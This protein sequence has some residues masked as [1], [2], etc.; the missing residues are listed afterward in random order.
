MKANANEFEKWQ[1]TNGVQNIFLSPVPCHVPPSLATCPVPHYNAFMV[2]QFRIVENPAARAWDDFVCAQAGHLLQSSAWGDLKAR[3]GWTV[4]RLAVERAGTCVAGA[5]ILF[6]RLPLGLCL[7]Y[8]PRGPVVDPSDRAAMAALVQAAAATARAHGAFLLKL[9][10]DW[11]LDRFSGI[12]VPEPL[13][14]FR[15]GTGHQPQSTIHL[16]LT[17]DLDTILAEMKPKWRYNIRLAARK[18]VS[19]REGNAADL[20]HFYQLL[21]VTSARD[22][23]AIHSLEYYRAAFELLHDHSRLFVAEFEREPLAAILVTAFA[24]QAIYLYG[25]SSNA[26]RE[27]MPNHALHWAAIQWAKTR[28]CARYDLWGIDDG[29]QP[30]Q[31]I[32]EGRKTKDEGRKSVLSLPPS[33]VLGPPSSVAGSGRSALPHGLYQFKHG[34]GGSLVHYVGA[35]DKVFSKVQYALYT[36]AIAFRRGGLT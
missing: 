19:V 22:R 27:C 10:P 5:Q 29:R 8:V 1:E 12:A 4:T 23:F 3:F 6:R 26:H 31:E 16:D 20:A 18:G 15:K 35:Y 34:F 25:A 13:R 24:G 17:R 30:T 2:E 9:E 7:A 11:P 36:R 33:S 14:G 21:Q 28:G 32:P